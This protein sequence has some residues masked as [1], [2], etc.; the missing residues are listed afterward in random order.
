MVGTEAAEAR[1]PAGCRGA[2][3]HL[4]SIST[5]RHAA[6]SVRTQRGVFPGDTCLCAQA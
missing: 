1:A 3:S 4:L 6:S 5:G 2:Q